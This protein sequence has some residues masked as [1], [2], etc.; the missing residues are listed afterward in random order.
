MHSLPQTHRATHTH[1]YGFTVL[2]NAIRI[3][4]DWIVLVIVPFGKL[5]DTLTLVRGTDSD[6]C[7]TPTE[8][9]RRHYTLEGG[10]SSSSPTEGLE[11]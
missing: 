3:G 2:L 4:L 1:L 10:E 7:G 9:I 11:T 5:G 6:S 8:K